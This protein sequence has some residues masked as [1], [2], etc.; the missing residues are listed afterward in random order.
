MIVYIGSPKESMVKLLEL[1]SEVRKI[2]CI[3]IYQQKIEQK[4]F[5]KLYYL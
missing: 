2:N 3:S 5:L 4:N 1:I